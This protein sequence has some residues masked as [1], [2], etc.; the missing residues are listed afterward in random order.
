MSKWKDGAQ[1][2]G[3]WQQEKCDDTSG[4]LISD[5]GLTAGPWP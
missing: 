1:D 5:K 4:N 2:Q 3:G